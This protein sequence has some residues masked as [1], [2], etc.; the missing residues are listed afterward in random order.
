MRIQ[1]IFTNDKYT[2]EE[3]IYK[4][5][6]LVRLKQQM[7]VNRK[8]EELKKEHII[9]FVPIRKRKRVEGL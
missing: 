5:K 2:P 9:H 7:H 6:L 8:I 4:R 1:Q 3:D